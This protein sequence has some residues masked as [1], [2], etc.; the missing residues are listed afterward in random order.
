VPAFADILLQ[1]CLLSVDTHICKVPFS[2][3]PT[4]SWS[5]PAVRRAFI[6]IDLQLLGR[7][8]QLGES[9]LFL[10]LGEVPLGAVRLAEKL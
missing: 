9:P 5:V 1:C 6:V 7:P 4:S 10:R 8:V 2:K 3:V